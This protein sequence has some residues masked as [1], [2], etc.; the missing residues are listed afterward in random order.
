MAKKRRKVLIVAYRFPPIGGGGVQRTLKF[1][2]YLPLYGWD[3]VVLTVKPWGLELRDD[4]MLHE[5]PEG[6]QIYRTF[7]FDLIRINQLFKQMCRRKGSH[8][9]PVC[10]KTNNRRDLFRAVKDIIHLVSIPDIEVGWLPFAVLQAKK[11]INTEH[12]DC[13]YSTSGP[14]TAHLVGLCL[15]HWTNR[16]WIAD[17]RD[18][19]TQQ[20]FASHRSIKRLKIEENLEL[21]VLKAADRAITVTKPIAD[22]FYQKYDQVSPGKFSVITNGY[23]ANDFSSTPSVIKKKS[24]KFIIVHTGSFYAL[25]TPI[26]FLKALRLLLDETPS[27]QRDI[28]VVFAGRWETRDDKIVH[29][30]GLKNVIKFVGYVAHQEGICLLSNSDVLL[31]IIASTAVNVYSGKIFEYL[32]IKKPILALV[33]PEGVAAVLIKKTRTGVVVNPEDIIP[34]KNEILRMYKRY[35]AG[36]LTINPELSII[37]KFERKSLTNDLAVI[38]NEVIAESKSV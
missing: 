7:A 13:V 17:F 34:I 19:W 32:A 20:H 8:P 12:V 31:L 27:I 36:T 15:K 14:A 26:Y 30:L 2:K 35:K 11:I 33:P 5:I 24:Q 38:L 37:S 25:Q 10:D 6:I 18:P 9:S 29:D 4:T 23:D 3:P 16:P 28:E 21:R 1:V 22:A